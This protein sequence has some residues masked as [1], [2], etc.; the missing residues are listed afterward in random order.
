MALF[1]AMAARTLPLNSCSG[2]PSGEEV[3]THWSADEP[4]DTQREERSSLD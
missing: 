1:G 3:L 4:P 2:E